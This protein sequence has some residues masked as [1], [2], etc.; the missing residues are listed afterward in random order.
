MMKAF[1]VLNPVAGRHDPELTKAS[2]AR[3]QTEGKWQYELYK[4]T[5]E[6]DLQEV[7]REARRH[8]TVDVV[9]A[10]GGDGC[11]FGYSP[12]RDGQCLCH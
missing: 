7:V 4:T 10:G 11:P 12:T 1:V 6:E 9:I 8:N 3:A 5:G 2:L